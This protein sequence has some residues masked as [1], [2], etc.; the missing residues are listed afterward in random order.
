MFGKLGKGVIMLFILFM[1]K[2]CR[3][4]PRG[5]PCWVCPLAGGKWP[6]L[7]ASVFDGAI[8]AGSRTYALIRSNWNQC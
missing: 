7:F 5:V 2:F 3:L 4:K 1:V 6:L 8:C